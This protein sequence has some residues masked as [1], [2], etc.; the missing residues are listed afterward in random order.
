MY[1]NYMQQSQNRVLL[2]KLSQ[3]V[4]INVSQYELATHAPRPFSDLL[5]GPICFI[6]P[7]VPYLWK[8]TVS[9]ITEC[10]HSRLDPYKCLP[11]QSNLNSAKA[12]AIYFFPYK[13]LVVHISPT[14]NGELN[15]NHQHSPMR[16]EGL[17]TTGCC[18][19]PRGVRLRHCYHHLSAMQ[20]SARCLTPWLRW[21]NLIWWQ[22]LY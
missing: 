4:S 18:Q 5:C 6:P 14:R 16:V 20:P 17:H 11:V 1:L 10:H 21:I 13:F 7:V 9:Y 3:S 8:S 22:S 12:F 19:A 15:S 2:L